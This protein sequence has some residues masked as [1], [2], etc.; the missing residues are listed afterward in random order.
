[1]ELRSEAAKRVRL[2]ALSLARSQR[3]AKEERRGGVAGGGGDSKGGPTEV[4]CPVALLLPPSTLMRSISLQQAALVLLSGVPCSIP[5]PSLSVFLFL[6]RLILSLLVK[7][8]GQREGEGEGARGCSMDGHSL[9]LR[10][11]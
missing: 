6:P 1:M 7:A 10:V 11:V 9:T 2:N 5:P 4:R 8:K 3:E